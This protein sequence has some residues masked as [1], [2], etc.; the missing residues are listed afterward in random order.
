MNL[1]NKITTFRIIMVGVIFILL[2]VPSL[3]DITGAMINIYQN[4]AVISSLS[5][6]NLIICGL[7]LIASFSDFLDGYLARKYN[8]VT[9]YGKFMDP[10][11]DKLLVDTVLLFFVLPMGSNGF[12]FSGQTGVPM[13]AC[14]IMI[15]RD[16]VVDAMRLIAM[17][18]NVVVAANKFGKVKTVLQMVALTCVLLNNWPFVYLGLS[19]NI[20]NI[21]CYLAGLASLLSGII[22]LVNNRNVFKDSKK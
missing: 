6:F 13:V 3:F 9:T 12:A 19:F 5:V 17:E 11:A 4:G 20:T 22:Y 10:I 16:L 15:A 8:L 7:F 2:L 18:K 14:I 1:P 21:I